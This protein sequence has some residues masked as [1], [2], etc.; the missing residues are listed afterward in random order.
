MG[1]AGDHLAVRTTLEG[2]MSSENYWRRRMGRRGFLGAASAATAGLA[3]VGLVGCGDDDSGGGATATKPAAGASAA[4]PGSATAPAVRKGGTVRYVD[5]DPNA[6]DIFANTQVTGWTLSSLV[7][8]NLI[9]FKND[10]KADPWD[11]T[12]QPMV[13][14]K[15][16]Q[17]DPLTY[18]FT[19]DP[20]VKFPEIAP[21]NGR[22]Y[23]A[24]DV[25]YT[26]NDMISKR[27][28]WSN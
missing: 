5:V 2:S 24:D 17:P 28:K 18:I 1:N 6:W 22:Q 12:I 8:D 3:A 14:A 10:A 16:E 9:S 21:V 15:W 13:A 27:D 4:A 7:R 19:L 26:F 20:R 23:T 25:V 11:T